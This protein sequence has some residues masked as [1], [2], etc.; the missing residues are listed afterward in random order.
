M[1]I[2]VADDQVSMISEYLERF[3]YLNKTNES[4]SKIDDSLIN[5][6]EYYNITVDGTLND[7]T[8][9]LINTPRC[10]ND[11][12]PYNAFRIHD[13]IWKKHDLKWYFPL[14]NP[15]IRNVAEKAFKVWE[16][17]TSL[18]FTFS[19][20]KPDI[21]LSFANRVHHHDCS[22]SCKKGK[23]S[24]T[25]DGKGYTLAHAFFPESDGSCVEIHLDKSEDWYYGID[26]IPDGATS[27]YTTLI[28]EIGHS[29]GLEHSSVRD[30]IMFAYYNPNKSTL[31]PDDIHA[32]N[33][34]YGT[35]VKNEESYNNN[36]ESNENRNNPPNLC[37]E[38]RPDSVLI[39]S[40]HHMYIFIKEW[41]WVMRVGDKNYRT[42]KL[43]KDYTKIRGKIS[44][45]YQ[46][47][48]NDLIVI[49]NNN[50]LYTIGFPNLIL[51]NSSGFQFDAKIT[52]VNS[53][54]NT[55]SGK[56]YLFYDNYFYLEL[57][58]CLSYKTKSYGLITELFSGIPS[59]VDTGYRYI[60]GNMY[61]LKN[62]NFY[63][64]NEF[65]NT[66]I[67]AGVFDWSLLGIECPN[68]NILS[69]LKDVLTRI[70]LLLI[71]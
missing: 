15:M 52:N 40:N 39:T 3:G 16:N 1:R 32:I 54:F 64:F 23:C 57:D 53:L 68:E 49:S 11:D 61:F 51:K 47:H 28:H 56:I 35:S 34:L 13:K 45:I 29:L 65:S 70:N 17:S 55:Y 43:L 20:E 58:S 4:I 26:N 67:R 62:N 48:E 27:L 22:P 63:E 46:N 31:S 9:S 36:R 41:V 33:Y 42:P 6:Q 30:S 44:N 2:V 60:N 19:H 71:R 10:G 37:N 59:D 8:M 24:F 7:E 66:L 14:A 18:R 69:Q 12:N 25:F 50:T 38:Q 21:V 5:F